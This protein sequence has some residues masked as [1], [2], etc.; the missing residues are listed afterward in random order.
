MK[1]IG[2]PQQL[3]HLPSPFPKA[4]VCPG[5]FR[6]ALPSNRQPFVSV[7]DR[8]RYLQSAVA[9]G[10]AERTGASGPVQSRTGCRAS[11]QSA[12]GGNQPILRWPSGVT[13]DLAGSDR[14]R[15]TVFKCAQGVSTS[16]LAPVELKHCYVRTHGAGVKGAGRSEG[17]EVMARV[18]EA[19]AA[20]HVARDFETQRFVVLV[21]DR[22]T[23]A[24]S[25]FWQRTFRR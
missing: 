8:Y 5:G 10:L 22:S 1:R 2:F 16:C 4:M 13:C 11:G 9:E 18:V 17:V 14:P 12:G 25:N 6:I 24:L 21:R 20:E 3:C 15:R 19:H 7:M 23:G